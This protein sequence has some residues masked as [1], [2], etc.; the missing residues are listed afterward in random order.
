MN[1][2]SVVAAVVAAAMAL[3]ACGGEGDPAPQT[4]NPSASSHPVKAAA[5]R[6]GVRAETL[7][8]A[9]SAFAASDLPHGA[10]ITRTEIRAATARLPEVCIVRGAI[11]SSP[12]STIN[13]VV[14]LPAASLWNGKTLTIGGGGLDGFIPTDDAF[15]QDRVAGPGGNRFVK[16]SSDSGHQVP[17]FDFFRDEAAFRNHAFEANHLALEVGTEV[18]TQFYG[19]PP[20]RR[21]MIGHSNGGRSAI[22]AMQRYPHDYDGVIALEPALS[23][24]LHQINLGPTVLRHI[25]KDPA[26]WLSPAKTALYARAETRACDALDGLEDGIIG[27][28][29]ACN[30]VPTDLLCTGADN[31]NCLTAG[32]IESIR[33]IYADRAVP[34]TMADGVSGY[35][36]F[37]RG[38]AATSDWTAYMFG[39]APG[40]PNAFNVNAVNG[41]ARFVS[42]DPTTSILTHDPTAF[43]P[44]YLRLSELM[45]P[46]TDI[47]EFV[48]HGGKLLIWYGL[49]DTCV[50][51]YRTVGYFDALKADLGRRKVRS[52]ARFLTTPSM[53]HDLDGP[54]TGVIDF[55]GAMDR[56]VERGVAPDQLVATTFNDAG[57]VPVR[58]RPVCEYPKFPRYDG[59]GDPSRAQSFFCS[60][61]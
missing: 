19:M 35:P 33:L 7:P 8:Q 12:L 3:L 5:S 34:G 46:T 30:Y 48:D 13:W 11:V 9:C 10:T 14:E 18:A 28:I 56:W 25:F 51:L 42:N 55:I 37:G 2:A 61:E 22:M 32:Q 53:G 4:S 41:A 26:N 50:S 54:G 21:Y 40:T 58:Q 57:T 52:F 44:Q 29:E 15:Y 6:P 43:L 1:R 45:D 59:T 60:D 39:N 47:S 24:Q 49:A 17:S 20:E 31:D 36:R 23:Q 38:G 16:I 27:N